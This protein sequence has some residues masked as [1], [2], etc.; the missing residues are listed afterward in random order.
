MQHALDA[1]P[2][3]R[4]RRGYSAPSCAGATPFISTTLATSLVAP[5]LP[6][7]LLV[8]R[9]LPLSL[10]RCHEVRFLPPRARPSGVRCLRRPNF[11]LGHGRR[12][13]RQ[14]CIHGCVGNLKR[15]WPVFIKSRLPRLAC[16]VN[17]KSGD[18]TSIKYSGTELQDKSKFTQLSS[19][20]G[21]CEQSAS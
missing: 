2:I 16:A 18:I 14:A 4:R 9:S 8:F 15:G 6:F 11:R 12:L 20:L 17:T 21:E 7:S 10:F 1:S 3:M 19:G 5:F 13:G